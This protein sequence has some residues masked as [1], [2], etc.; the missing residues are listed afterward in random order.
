MIATTDAMKSPYP[1]KKVV[2]TAA[3]DKI[4]Q[5]QIANPRHST[6][7]CPRGIVRYLGHNIVESDPN[8]IIFAAILVPRMEIAQPPAARNTAVLV[9]ADQYLVIIASRRSH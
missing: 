6:R 2:N 1:A 3:D 7:N 5:G 4:F 9:P 8:G